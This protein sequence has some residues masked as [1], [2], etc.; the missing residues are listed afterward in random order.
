MAT[1]PPPNMW[2]VSVFDGCV[3]VVAVIC[4]IVCLIIGGTLIWWAVAVFG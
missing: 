1:T 2:V 3:M 4:A